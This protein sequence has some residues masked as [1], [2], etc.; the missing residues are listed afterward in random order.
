MPAGKL[1]RRGIISVCV[2]VDRIISGLNEQRLVFQIKDLLYDVI[3]AGIVIIPQSCP[4]VIKR[5]LY[6]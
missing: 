1:L 6:I 5:E 2:C 4:G 3:Y